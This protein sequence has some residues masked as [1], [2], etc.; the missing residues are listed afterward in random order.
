M[1]SLT[2]YSSSYPLER[3]STRSAGASV[4]PETARAEAPRPAA[5]RRAEGEPRL[6]AAGQLTPEQREQIEKLKQRDREVKAHEQAHMSAGGRYIRGGPSYTFQLGPDGQRYAIGGEVSIDTS[7]EKTPQQ[8]IAKARIVQAAALAVPDPSAAD[9]AAAAKASK[10][11][12]EARQQLAAEQA[13]P[14]S[15]ASPSEQAK[16]A[17]TEEPPDAADQARARHML[18]AIRTYAEQPS[19]KGMQLDIAI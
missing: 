10:M 13:S 18:R 4:R 2:G 8:T 11:E 1:I 17:E 16:P 7:P 12:I 3:V 5:D 19:R 14:A 15:P 9:R 6:Q